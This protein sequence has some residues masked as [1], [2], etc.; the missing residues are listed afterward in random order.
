MTKQTLHFTN[1]QLIPKSSWII[2]FSQAP[3]TFQEKF[4]C[5]CHHAI[6]SIIHALWGSCNNII[7]ADAKLSAI[8]WCRNPVTACLGCLLLHAMTHFSAATNLTFC[9]GMLVS[10]EAFCW[11]LK[12]DEKAESIGL[13]SSQISKWT[14]K[15]TWDSNDSK[16]NSE[17]RLILSN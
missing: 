3:K 10:C 1:L 4:S 17:F 2:V 5:T 12:R 7:I 9:P 13:Y 14:E 11:F 16:H 6:F 8:G 15:C